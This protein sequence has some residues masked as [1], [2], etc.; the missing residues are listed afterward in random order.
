M[1]D[2]IYRLVYARQ[3]RLSSALCS[4]VKDLFDKI[5]TSNY[6][7]LRPYSICS[8]RSRSVSSDEK[9]RPVSVHQGQDSQDQCTLYII[10][11]HVCEKGKEESRKAG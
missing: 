7:L 9:G 6:H 1:M 2:G 4:K 5:L 11:A 8:P 10:H 3:F